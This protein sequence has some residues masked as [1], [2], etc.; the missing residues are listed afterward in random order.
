[1]Q[2]ALIE[3]QTNFADPP[4]HLLK[5]IHMPV[6]LN[7]LQNVLP[8]SKYSTENQAPPDSI[9]QSRCF[10]RGSIIQMAQQIHLPPIRDYETQSRQK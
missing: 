4:D 1:L 6:N 3:Q 8:A 2:P 9:E 7:Q 5:T 10:D